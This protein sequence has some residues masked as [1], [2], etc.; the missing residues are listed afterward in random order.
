[1]RQVTCI[2][3]HGGLH[4]GSKRLGMPPAE[5]GYVSVPALGADTRAG[6]K[7]IAVG[8]TVGA[9]EAP[10]FIADGFHFVNENGEADQCTGGSSCWCG[11]NCQTPPGVPAPQTDDTTGTG[12]DS[13][14]AGPEGN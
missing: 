5:A 13:A 9:P 7:P 12:A 4:R 1:M 14:P 3:P 6:Q 11:G 10:A 2:S 8:A